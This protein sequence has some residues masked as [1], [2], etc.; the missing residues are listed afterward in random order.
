MNHPHHGTKKDRQVTHNGAN[1]PRQ[2]HARRQ[3]RS[4][5]KGGKR[6]DRL[7]GTSPQAADK[8]NTMEAREKRL[9]QDG[10]LPEGQRKRQ[11]C[12]EPDKNPS[13]RDP[14]CPEEEQNNKVNRDTPSSNKPQ[15]KWEEGLNKDG[16]SDEG[17]QKEKD[18]ILPHKY[19]PSDAGEEDDHAQATPCLAS[20]VDGSYDREAV[21]YWA[22]WDDVMF[23][24]KKDQGVEE[25]EYYDSSEE[26]YTGDCEAVGPCRNDFA[27]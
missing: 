26:E 11:R 19:L 21:F 14:T 6:E 15:D 5:F 13:R 7:Q 3:S 12:N 18:N 10:S 20:I 16:N 25:G 22:E 8:S 4:S 24:F 17:S 27:T 1:L 9:V 23:K 2:E